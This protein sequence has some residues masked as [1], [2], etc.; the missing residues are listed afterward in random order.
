MVSEYAKEL[1]KKG[2]TVGLLVPDAPD[3]PVEE[4]VIAVKSLP[5]FFRSDT[6]F[7]YG[8]WGLSKRVESFNPDVIHIHSPGNLGIWARFWA[9]KKNIK[10]VTTVHGTPAF[11]ASYLPFSFLF[12]PIIRF[13]GWKFWKWFLQSSSTVLAP[14][15]YVISALEKIGITDH[16]IRVPFWIGPLT[17]SK[18]KK[19][20]EVTF[21]FFGR[22]DPDKNLPFLLEGWSHVPFQHKKLVIA[23]RDLGSAK[24]DLTA[25]AEELGCQDTVEVLGTVTEKKKAEL[26]AKADFFVMP[27]KVEVQSIVTYQAALSGIPVVVANASALPEIVTHSSVP[28]LIFDP[29]NPL[30]LANTLQDCCENKKSYTQKFSLNADFA[31]AFTKD[32]VLRIL[33][34]DVYGNMHSTP[35]WKVAQKL[36]GGVL[37]LIGFILSPLSWWNDLVVNFPLSYALALPFGMI[38]ESLFVPA[39]VAAYWVTNILGLLLLQKGGSQLITNP[40][41]HATAK[42]E[43]RST[44]LWSTL[45]TILI[46]VLVATGILSFPSEFLERL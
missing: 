30:N 24:A 19:S 8:F 15:F 16:V 42:D 11:S 18:T 14:S 36:Q 10:T 6:W 25:L 17:T 31:Q 1:R 40:N 9:Q 43:I 41:K 23:G 26:F 27:S 44:L 46:M 4:N 7:T 5:G 22:L 13:L 21:L 39:F 28:H 12:S 29:D 20:K 3:L 34:K 32:H 38:R 45:Y 37:A 35:L 2:H 33:E